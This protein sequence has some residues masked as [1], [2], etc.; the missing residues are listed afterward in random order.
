MS[1]DNFLQ[2]VEDTLF[3]RTHFGVIER[4]LSEND[5]D[6][7]PKNIANREILIT[8]PDEDEAWRFIDAMYDDEFKFY[9]YGPSGPVKNPEKGTT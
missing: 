1:A 4:K 9:E 6:S 2:V 5:Y 7:Y 8:T 3:G